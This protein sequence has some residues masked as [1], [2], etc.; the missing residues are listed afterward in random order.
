MDIQVSSE[1]KHKNRKL[2]INKNIN[3]KS[4]NSKST[5]SK[6][7]Y[8]KSTNSKSTNSKSLNSKSINSKSTNSKNIINK[9]IISKNIITKDTNISNKILNNNIDMKN[10]DINEDTNNLINKNSIY[11]KINLDNEIN[12][13]L[14]S[15]YTL[16]YHNSN[17]NNWDLDSY[18]NIC[19]FSSVIDVLKCNL[20]M[21]NFKQ[22]ITNGMFFIMKDNIKPTWEDKLN[23]NGGCISW[24]INKVNV[25]NI[26][27]NFVELFLCNCF[28]IF[29]KYELNGISISPKKHNNILKLWLGKEISE[30]EL[31]KIDLNDKC[32]FDDTCKMF[33]KHQD[34]INNDNQKNE[35]IDKNN[36]YN[37]DTKATKD[38]K[39]TK[40][41]KDTKD[42]KD[43]KDYKDYKD[44]KDNKDNKDNKDIKDSKDYKD[45]KDNNN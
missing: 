5:N 31:K 18:I 19:E 12:L 8:S 4:T 42:N 41:Y 16:W 23:I 21:Q 45:I 36:E 20:S 35:K 6:S 39:D 25:I 33:K 34:N 40:D 26:W 27:I 38:N 17:N 10:N 24:K 28:D 15:K 2:T 11:K 30:E 1:F 13:S 7:T 9:N 32:L 22:L 14:K 29:E 43:T 3:S 37:L 44:T